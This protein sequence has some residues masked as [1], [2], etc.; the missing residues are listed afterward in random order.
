MEVKGQGVERWDQPHIVFLSS[1]LP[2]GE[3]R[4]DYLRA[5]EGDW[6]EQ[7]QCTQEIGY[8]VK[9]LGAVKKRVGISYFSISYSLFWLKQ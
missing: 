6:E 9:S 1:L 4:L 5:R 8:N 2:P 7:P 3:G